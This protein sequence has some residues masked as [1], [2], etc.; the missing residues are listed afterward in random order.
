[1]FNYGEGRDVVREAVRIS[2]FPPEVKNE[3]PLGD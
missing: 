3:D 1:L 2:L